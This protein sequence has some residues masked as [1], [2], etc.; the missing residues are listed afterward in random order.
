MQTKNQ[1]G[2][3]LRF[4]RKAKDLS[5]EEFGDVSSRTYVSALERDIYTPTLEKI[6]ELASVIGIHPLTLITLAYSSKLD[7]KSVKSLVQLVTDESIAICDA[8]Q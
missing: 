5:Q 1:F 2:R 8:R 4:A 3:A 7:P 6:E